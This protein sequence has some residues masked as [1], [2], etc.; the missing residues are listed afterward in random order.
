MLVILVMSSYEVNSVDA[1]INRISG[2]NRY[3]TAVEISRAGWDDSNTVVLASGETFPDAL[4]GGPLAYMLE[5]PILLT[6]KNKLPSETL[7]ELQR[8]NVQEVYLLGGKAAIAESVENE[9]AEIVGEINRI[10]GADRFETAAQ[11]ASY[12]PSSKAVVA[13]GRNFPDALAVA[14]YAAKQGIPIVLTDTATLPSST[15]KVTDQ[16]SKT[17]VVG[18]YGV[19]SAKVEEKLPSPTRYGGENRFETAKKI[20]EAF[21]MGSTQAYVATGESFADALAGSVLAATKN[22]PI[23]LVK[24]EEI[25]DPVEGL[26]ENY[27]AHTILGGVNAVSATV[28]QNLSGDSAEFAFQGVS[29]GSTETELLSELGNPQRIESAR[30][31]FD[32]YIYN[33]NYAKYLQVGVS[34]GEVVALFV[35]SDSWTSEHG[36]QLGLSQSRVAEILAEIGA[37]S[38]SSQNKDYL[39]KGM[40]LQF[41]YDQYDGNTL[42]G[43]QLMKEDLKSGYRQASGTTLREG[44]E[45]QILDI[46]N[47]YRVRHNVATLQEDEKIEVVARTHSQDMAERSFFDHTNPDGLSPFQRM[48]AA[49]IT[50]RAAGEN[51]AAGYYNAIAVHDGWVNSAGHRQNILSAAYERLGVGVHFGGSYGVY[52]TQ[53]FYTPK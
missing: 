50:Y 38:S 23:L 14:P 52:Y 34:G 1:S 4:A 5:A 13:N 51:I 48:A 6:T 36:L 19:I 39:Y 2:E 16:K 11:I 49:G 25:P 15:K 47:A 44:F 46:T 40:N 28:Q 22:A 53:N 17:I 42:S 26:V 24:K 3:D 12:L 31:D 41:Y 20:T 33:Q 43:L 37:E 27:D 45:R 35:N 7:E 32:W 21:P 18:S 29:V 10:G 9:L 8:L 30:Y